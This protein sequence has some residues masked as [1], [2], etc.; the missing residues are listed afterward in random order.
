LAPD[1][2]SLACRWDDSPAAGQS[3]FYLITKDFQTKN[4]KNEKTFSFII[5]GILLADGMG[6]DSN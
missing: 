2:Y 5:D 1:V 3:E 6:T 4:F